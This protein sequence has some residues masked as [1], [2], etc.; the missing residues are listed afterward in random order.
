MAQGVAQRKVDDQVEVRTNKARSLQ[1]H[2]FGIAVEGR[3][4]QLAGGDRSLD[5]SDGSRLC[6]QATVSSILYGAFV[7]GRYASVVHP[8]VNPSHACWH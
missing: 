2:E 7:P 3:A 8:D 5:R 1:L 4:G 6:P